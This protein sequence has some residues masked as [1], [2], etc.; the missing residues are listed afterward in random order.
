M[1]NG[2][3]QNTMSILFTS[4]DDKN[5]ATLNANTMAEITP[6]VIN[7]TTLKAIVTAK[8]LRGNSYQFN[9]VFIV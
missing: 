7:T 4:N 8:Q 9:G 2:K 6:T 1:Q 5:Y 3:M